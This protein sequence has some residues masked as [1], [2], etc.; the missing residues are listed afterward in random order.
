VRR[1]LK[2]P[3]DGE[4]KQNETI[5]QLKREVSRLSKEN[6][7]L[8]DEVENIVK[9]VRPRKDPVAQKREREARLDATEDPAKTMTQDEWRKDF[10]AK[11]KPRLDK[12]LGAIRDDEEE[13]D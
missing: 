2:Y 10:I 6:R 11:F 12:R 5:K 7:I 13:N 8:R 9:P 4:R 1:N 3:K